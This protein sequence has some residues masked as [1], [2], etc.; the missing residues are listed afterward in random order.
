MCMPVMPKS[1]SPKHMAE[2]R[3]WSAVHSMRAALHLM[4]RADRDRILDRVGALEISDL[5]AYQQDAT[6]AML[7]VL[8]AFSELRE[9]IPRWREEDNKEGANEY[10]I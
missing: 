2:A 9:A 7:Q 5:E 6:K 3:A 1:R 10:A 8:K 4:E